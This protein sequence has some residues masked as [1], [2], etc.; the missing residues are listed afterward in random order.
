MSEHH[1]LQEYTL[2]EC[3][4]TIKV[5]PYN[6]VKWSLISHRCR[7]ICIISMRNYLSEIPLGL[8]EENQYS[9]RKSLLFTEP[10]NENDKAPFEAAVD[11]REVGTGSP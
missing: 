9:R 4:Y 3:P 6:A 8:G 11:Q 10:T 2:N 5:W 7:E 1:S